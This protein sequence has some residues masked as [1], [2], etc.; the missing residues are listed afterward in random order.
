MK[1]RILS[2][3]IILSAVST[4][5]ATLALIQD[6]ILND[7][8]S[9]VRGESLYSRGSATAILHL[10]KYSETKNQSDFQNFLK[11]INIP[12]G[13]KIAREAL[14]LETPD[15]ELARKGFLQG[16]NHKDDI[17]GMIFF[18]IYFQ[19]IHYV[20]KA[21]EHWV[22]ADETN[23]R[24]YELGKHIKE[25]IQDKDHQS[26]LKHELEELYKLAQTAQMHQ[27]NFSEVLSEGARWVKGILMISTIVIFILLMSFALY[28]S[29]KI[30]EDLQASENELTASK[31]RLDYAINGVNDGLWDWN[32]DTDEV[33]YSPR[34]LS[35]LGY[36]PN[37]FP[38]TLETWSLL[39]H[40]EYKETTLEKINKHIQGKSHNFEAEFQMKH[41]DGH[42]I[43]ILSRGSLVRDENGDI[44]TPRRI[45]GTH[46]DIT[47]QKELQRDLKKAKEKA[48]EST[49]SKDH[50]LA[51][52]SH[53]IRTPMTG[54]IGFIE[55]LAKNEKD[56]KRFHQLEIIKN[57]GATLLDI[58]NDI[59]D[60][61]KIENSKLELELAPFD[62]NDVFKNSLDIFKSLASS[63][64][65][66]IQKIIDEDL[67]DCI[68][69]DQTRLKQVVFNLM[70]NA[71]KFTHEGGKIS[72]HLHYKKEKN[73]IYIAV[74]DS[75]VGIAQENLEKIFHAFSQED[76]S[77]TRK[78]G[79]TGLGLSIASRLVELMGS[80]LQ[81]QSKVGVGS[82]FYFELPVKICKLSSDQSDEDQET[83]TIVFNGHILIVEDNK[84]N[85]MLMG[86]VLDEL[87]LSYD[88]ANDGAEAILEFKSKKYDAIL[89]DENMP[90]MNGIEAT[91]RIREIEQESLLKPTPIIAVTANALTGDKEKFINAGMDDYIPKPYTEEQVAEALKN[92]LQEK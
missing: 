50:F 21:I 42:W 10:I 30:L 20:K 76:S 91:K 27:Q 53:E 58:I 67:P 19:D 17:D 51:S 71:I 37:Y 55:Q 29:R 23:T 68:Q 64:N 14:Q 28:I 5:L 13:D 47:A 60:F 3:I 66:T 1:K 46:V 78:Y 72:F 90:N 59:L 35:M 6:E 73:S 15:K 80:Q 11:E 83:P 33:Y 84:T 2:I 61:S 32:L 22:D 92:F 74:A 16:E 57:S 4:I 40:P 54:I 77:T 86:V 18:F 38:S 49:R 70:S 24:I 9:Y 48:E 88:V 34:W 39:V 56:P 45:V 69:G 41:K 89:M 82:K 36:E 31:Q 87:G 63:K 26:D 79:G 81:V 65:I 7:V 52:M 12:L 44:E 85:Q 8:R 25:N 75:G 43:Y 62:I